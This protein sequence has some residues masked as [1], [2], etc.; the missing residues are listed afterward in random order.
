MQTFFGSHLFLLW[1]PWLHS[2]FFIPRFLAYGAS[3][4]PQTSLSPFLVGCRVRS[5]LP[6]PDLRASQIVQGTLSLVTL[7]FYSGKKQ[8]GQ[9]FQE[10]NLMC[11]TGELNVSIFTMPSLGSSKASNA[12]GLDPLVT[13]P[14]PFSSAGS[15]LTTPQNYRA[16]VVTGTPEKS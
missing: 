14:S 9:V 15:L 16:G 10:S 11:L 7:G 8:R 6:L 1:L 4:P 13:F 3:V 5:T 12:F 2:A